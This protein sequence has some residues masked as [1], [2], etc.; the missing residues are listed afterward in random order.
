MK[1][2]ESELFEVMKILNMDVEKSIEKLNSGEDFEYNARAYL[3]AYATW[4]EGTLWMFKELIRKIEYQWY[5][6]MPLELQLYLLEN[7]W[8]VKSSGEIYIEDKKIRTKDN[9]KAFFQLAKFFAPN[10][11]VDFECKEWG[12]VSKFYYFRD[13]MMHPNSLKSL[14]YTHQEISNCDLGRKWLWKQISDVGQLIS[15]RT[16]QE[17]A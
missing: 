8:D 15:K 7:D 9:I 3:R 12:Y 2:E 5:K 13:R 17:D 1:T 4:V 10:F 14:T 16:E 11:T 6:E